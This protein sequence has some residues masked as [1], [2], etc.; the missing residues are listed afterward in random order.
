MPW[1]TGISRISAVREGQAVKK[2]DVMF[3]VL[4]ILYKAKLDAKLA[5]ARLAE[6][7]WNNTKKLYDTE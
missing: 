5:E 3:K 4:P 2:G 6:L 1:T 7:E